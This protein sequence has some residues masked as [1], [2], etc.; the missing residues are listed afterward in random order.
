METPK[1]E[2]DRGV[3]GRGPGVFCVGPVGAGRGPGRALESGTEIFVDRSA[4]DAWDRAG[5]NGL[6]SWQMTCHKQ[7]SLCILGRPGDARVLEITDHR[8]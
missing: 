6:K 7:S 3:Y 5:G 2:T 1:L 8:P 4:E